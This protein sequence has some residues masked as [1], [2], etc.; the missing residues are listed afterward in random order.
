MPPRTRYRTRSQALSEVDELRLLFH[1][2]PKDIRAVVQADVLNYTA[3]IEYLLAN[4]PTI[5][6]KGLGVPRRSWCGYVCKAGAWRK[7][8][9]VHTAE[10]WSRIM[11]VMVK[12]DRREMK[13]VHPDE[14]CFD[15]LFT[16][17]VESFQ[18]YESLQ[19]TPSNRRFDKKPVSTPD[20]QGKLS[21]REFREFYDL[22]DSIHDVAVLR[23]H[24]IRKALSINYM[25]GC[26][27]LRKRNNMLRERILSRPW[28]AVEETQLRGSEIS[29]FE[30]MSHDGD[31][32]R[33]IRYII[34]KFPDKTIPELR[35]WLDEHSLKVVG[36]R[37][38]D[39]HLKRCP[40]N[41]DL[42]VRD[43]CGQTPLEELCEK[44]MVAALAASGSYHLFRSIPTYD[45][46]ISPKYV[47]AFLEGGGQLKRIAKPKLRWTSVARK[48]ILDMVRVTHYSDVRE[49]LMLR[50]ETDSLLP[51]EEDCDARGITWLDAP[52]D[53]QWNFIRDLNIAYVEGLSSTETPTN[54]KAMANLVIQVARD[55]RFPEI[56]I[57]HHVLRTGSIQ[58]PV[59][60]KKKASFK[61]VA[62]KR[63]AKPK[64]P[65]LLAA[66]LKN[67]VEGEIVREG[68]LTARGI[69]MLDSVKRK[70]G[71]LHKSA[72]WSAKLH[73]STKSVSSH[74]DCNDWVYDAF[75]PLIR[76]QV[77]DRVHRSH[78]TINR[79]KG[80]E[81]LDKFCSFFYRQSKKSRERAT[82][83]VSGQPA[84]TS[85][86][87]TKRQK[88][89]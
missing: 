66:H 62:G 36:V 15:K 59:D 53:R 35:F 74:C 3:P 54:A 39:N 42:F 63:L 70:L 13:F 80:R 52:T 89:H 29:Q 5:T 81:R 50:D 75:L 61:Y 8:L 38:F 86:F 16:M 44:H 18:S 82:I 47:Q 78:A 56:D 2:L 9:T 76:H 27:M 12:K 17:F 19:I 25:V 40:T 22:S 10:D 77:V 73:T 24:L 85:M 45:L 69:V 48:S 84:I 6:Y 34:T 88:R 32:P 21:P 46:M 71:K 31:M 87:G 51:E 41:I 58:F 1:A 67:F 43:R 28:V 57:Q 60:D 64:V 72:E 11:H 83:R 79:C 49:L 14:P 33:H 55:A 68:V 4:T 7:H 20:D 37:R 30:K 65:L 23:D 26:Y